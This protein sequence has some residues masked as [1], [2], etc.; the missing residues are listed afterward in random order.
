MISLTSHRWD[1]SAIVDGNNPA[2]VDMVN[3]CNV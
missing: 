1:T 3:I 2:P